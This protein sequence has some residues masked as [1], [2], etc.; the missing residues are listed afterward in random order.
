MR[1]LGVPQPELARL[2]V[3]VTAAL[4]LSPPVLE[5]LTVGREGGEE[6]FWGALEEFW[7]TVPSRGF[8]LGA[9][10]AAAAAT[11]A[12][13]WAPSDPSPESIAC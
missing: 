7:S 2:A 10:N 8:V 13:D 4:L 3:G 1:E 6:S 5:T 11:A 12:A 9:E